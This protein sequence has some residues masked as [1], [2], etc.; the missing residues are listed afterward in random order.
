[1]FTQIGFRQFPPNLTHLLIR[2]YKMLLDTDP[3]FFL[4]P[5]QNNA[6]PLMFFALDN[7]KIYPDVARKLTTLGKP[8][9]Q[10]DRWG[11]TAKQWI[12][13]KAL[14]ANYLFALDNLN[15][16]LSS[17][18]LDISFWD[19]VGRESTYDFTDQNNQYFF[20]E[21]AFN[22]VLLNQDRTGLK[23]SFLQ[24]N[25]TTRQNEANQLWE[26]FFKAHDDL[27]VKRI[28]RVHGG[29]NGYMDRIKVTPNAI[30][31]LGRISSIE[32]YLCYPEG[33][34]TAQIIRSKILSTGGTFGINFKRTATAN[35]A[36]TMRDSIDAFVRDVGSTS[37]SEVAQEIM[38]SF[39]VAY[40]LSL[41]KAQQDALDNHQVN[42]VILGLF[43]ALNIHSN[44]SEDS[45]SEIDR[46]VA[47][48]KGCSASAIRSKDRYDRIAELIGS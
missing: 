9:D 5:L 40:P 31:V 24:R 14:G 37:W 1:M 26:A 34:E 10:K 33:R 27:V 17:E 30:R 48:K 47:A 32:D 11:Y 15:H 18:P 2:N 43:T 3:D 38:N 8:V 44:S 19:K 16:D 35:E 28:S 4:T 12:G 6:T 41:E 42:C 45:F 22:E 7:P 36:K 20:D 23:E 39:F 29:D 13:K 25:I 21:L 46:L